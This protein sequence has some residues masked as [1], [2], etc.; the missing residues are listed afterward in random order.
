M[1]VCPWFLLMFLGVVVWND[2]FG[3]AQKDDKQDPADVDV[4]DTSTTTVDPN[5]APNT[6]DTVSCPNLAMDATC[7]E[8]LVAGCAMTLGDCLTSCDA[9]ADAPC[10][11]TKYMNGTEAQI[12]DMMQSY[13]DDAEICG[14]SYSTHNCHLLLNQNLQILTSLCGT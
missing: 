4:E 2:S 11:S 6:T 13:E 1:R 9:I 14:T 12:C 8:C 5:E 7:E 3:L 10:W